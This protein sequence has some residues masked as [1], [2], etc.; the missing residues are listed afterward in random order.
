MH[1]LRSLDYVELSQGDH[2]WLCRQS[3][4]PLHLHLTKSMS[5]NGDLERD[6][7]RLAADARSPFRSFAKLLALLVWSR[8]GRPPPA[9]P[10]LLPG[11]QGF[12]AR[13]RSPLLL[14]RFERAPAHFSVPFLVPPFWPDAIYLVLLPLLVAPLRAP[15]L[16]QGCIQLRSWWFRFRSLVPALVPVLLLACR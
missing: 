9:V 2:Y 15:F 14:T 1:P 11:Y 12:A 3:L 10:P 16:G 7:E 5:N 13:R 6:A 4:S 8:L